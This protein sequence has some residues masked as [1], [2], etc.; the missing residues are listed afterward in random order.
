MEPCC[1]VVLTAANT[2]VLPIFAFMSTF[3]MATGP[4]RATC[5]TAL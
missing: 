1:C 4:G 5:S 2:S 3:A